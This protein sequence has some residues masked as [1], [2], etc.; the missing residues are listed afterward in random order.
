MICAKEYDLFC[1]ELK[2]PSCCICAVIVPLIFVAAVVLG[3]LGMIYVPESMGGFTV[4]FA[5]G[6]CGAIIVLFYS[7]VIAIGSC[8]PPVLPLRSK[9]TVAVK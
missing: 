3:I 8:V 1:E 2:D 4:L 5:I 6:V 9:G 7:L